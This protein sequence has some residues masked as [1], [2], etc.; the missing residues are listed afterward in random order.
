MCARGVPQDASEAL[1][2]QLFAYSALIQSGSLLPQD[3]PGTP[4]LTPPPNGRLSHG[5]DKSS[6][7]KGKRGHPEGS[8]REGGEE[9]GEGEGDG[10]E[11]GSQGLSPE[12]GATVEGLLR[13][14]SAKSFLK[15][16][17][18]SLLMALMEQ[19]R[20]LRG[21]PICCC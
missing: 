19:V 18:A 11:E 3:A 17:A 8:E 1:L 7:K 21:A 12:V 13:L 6:K 14:A 2:G 20:E 10:S 4:P 5:H 9:E 16:P 15:E